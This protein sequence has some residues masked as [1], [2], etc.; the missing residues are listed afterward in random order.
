ME[1]TGNRND[2]YFLCENALKLVD[3]QLKVFYH[4]LRNTHVYFVDSRAQKCAGNNA[5][6]KA[7]F[8][9]ERSGKRRSAA[10]RGENF[11][12]EE[13]AA[14]A[15]GQASSPAEKGR[16][17]AR[18]DSA[19]WKSGGGRPEREELNTAETVEEVNSVVRSVTPM[20]KIVKIDFELTSY[21]VVR[22]QGAKG[23]EEEEEGFSG[24]GNCAG[25]VGQKDGKWIGQ[26]SYHPEGSELRSY[27]K[28][29][30]SRFT[31]PTLPHAIFGANASVGIFHVSLQEA[32]QR[33]AVL[34]FDN[35]KFIPANFQT[36]CKTRSSVHVRLSW[37]LETLRRSR[38]EG[39]FQTLTSPAPSVEV[40]PISDV[41]SKAKCGNTARMDDG[42]SSLAGS[43]NN[44]RL[45]FL[46]PRKP[47]I[48]RDTFVEIHQA[49]AFGLTLLPSS[50]KLQQTY[51]PY[52]GLIKNE[53]A[54]DFYDFGTGVAAI[55]RY[56]KRGKK[57]EIYLQLKTCE[58]G[59]LV[60]NSLMAQKCNNQSIK[61]FNVKA[62]TSPTIA[63]LV[64]KL[65]LDVQDHARQAL[66]NYGNGEW[67]RSLPFRQAV[68][69]KSPS[70]LAG[71][72][73]ILRFCA[74]K[75]PSSFGTLQSKIADRNQITSVG[76]KDE[77]HENPTTS[78]TVCQHLSQ[79]PYVRHESAH[80]DK[81]TRRVSRLKLIIKA[82][83]TKQGETKTGAATAE[84]SEGA[85]T[86]QSTARNHDFNKDETCYITSSEEL[87]SGNAQMRRLQEL[88]ERAIYSHL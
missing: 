4:T 13:E 25:K 80:R 60:K 64:V 2:I 46:P 75:F 54:S 34:K 61:C 87:L 82:L 50:D 33:Q 30:N 16:K 24:I 28:E 9:E 42:P 22:E 10:R 40:L 58:L 3:G 32:I 55:I 14:L 39:I 52:D 7:C 44:E 59:I 63:Q 29:G 1:C 6:F 65:G 23:L 37:K 56:T 77:S 27:L 49:N 86:C 73:Q 66:T 76:G 51:R 26:A 53:L 43:Y 8:G 11:A 20:F 79:P 48:V 84:K 31:Q 5:L 71:R 21:F 62:H 15:S 38:I 70:R 72:R 36:S 83:M 69:I 88:E 74:L 41:L 47:R 85:S 19:G 12:G 17:E 35:S 57:N 81:N 68:A 67:Q 78:T 45:G 18:D